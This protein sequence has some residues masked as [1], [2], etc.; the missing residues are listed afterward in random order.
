MFAMKYAIE[1]AVAGECE[2]KCEFIGGHKGECEACQVSNDEND[3]GYFSYC[4]TAQ[5]I[6]IEN[7]FNVEPISECETCEGTGTVLDYNKFTVDKGKWMRS[8]E[9]TISIECPECEGTGSV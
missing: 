8:F 7:G 5:S 9:E 3:W 2:G 1:K 6:D 4:E